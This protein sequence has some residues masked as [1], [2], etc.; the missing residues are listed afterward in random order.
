MKWIVTLERAC[1]CSNPIQREVE[2]NTKEQAN[3]K[4][5]ALAS[6]I[7]RETGEQYRILRVES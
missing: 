4:A 5:L 6:K 3:S 2:A 7:Y 1:K